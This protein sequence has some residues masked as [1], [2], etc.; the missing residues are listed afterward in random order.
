[1]TQPRTAPV[2]PQADCVASPKQSPG[3]LTLL[4]CSLVSPSAEIVP[5]QHAPSPVFNRF[6]ATDEFFDRTGNPC[7]F[8]IQGASRAPAPNW[9]AETVR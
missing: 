6:Q 2:P 4:A 9:R 3:Q 7:K 5:N 1:M 8:L